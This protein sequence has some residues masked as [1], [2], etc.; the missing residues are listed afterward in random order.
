[1]RAAIIEAMG[2][3]PTVGELPDP[4][5][6]AGE[7]LIDVDVATLNALDLHIAAGRYR[8]GPP[9][10]PYAPGVEGVGRVAA[11][12]GLKPGT[13]VRFEVAGLH[14]GYGQNGSVAAR[15]VAP[16]AIVAPLPDD[17]DD[18]TAAALGVTGIT[19][20][21]VLE[22]AQVREGE[23]VAVLGATGA[24]G[25]ALIQLARTQGAGRIVAAGR[26]AD[27]L[28]DA[29]DLGADAAVSIDEHGTREELSAAL[30]EAAGGGVDLILDPL[31][32]EPALAAIDAGSVG[33]RLVNYG[34][35]AGRTAE[36]PSAALLRRNVTVR[37]I[38]TALDAPAV[39]AQAY[40]AVLE[41]VRAGR[42]TIAH[43]AFALDAVGEAWARQQQP[44]GRKVL[45][46]L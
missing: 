27:R 10:T 19:S 4:T 9:H 14:P 31:W 12:D 25:R 33:V 28:A 34:Q 39:R 23:A 21:R 46:R 22:V 43:D 36:V 17:V 7:V 32:G 2:E 35:V 38:S 44:R 15:A 30:R 20:W 29:L 24:L 37:G 16:A 40:A 42:L 6:E 5:P 18:T 8:D 1:M 26:D 3:A 45:V 11:G 41:E 13:R